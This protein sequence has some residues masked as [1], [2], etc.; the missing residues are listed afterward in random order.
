MT[1]NSNKISDNINPIR[2]YFKIE[3][4]KDGKV[5]NTEENHNLIMNSARCSFAN[6]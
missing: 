5:I 4:I 6:V 3:T 2:G 1:L